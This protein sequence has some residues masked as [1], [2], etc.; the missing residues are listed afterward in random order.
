MEHIRLISGRCADI[1]DRNDWIDKEREISVSNVS[2]DFRGVRFDRNSG[3][4]HDLDKEGTSA[5]Y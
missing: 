3:E 2:G 1:S 5:L 4:Y